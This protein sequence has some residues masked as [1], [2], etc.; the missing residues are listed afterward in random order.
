MVLLNLI[1]VFLLL[2]KNMKSMEELNKEAR[3]RN[4][5]ELDKCCNTFCLFFGWGLVIALMIYAIV[6]LVT[7]PSSN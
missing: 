3:I 2:K 7:R 6:L 4:D 1:N 5:K